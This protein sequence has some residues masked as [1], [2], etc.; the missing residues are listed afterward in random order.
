M[1]RLTLTLF[2]LACEQEAAT[3]QL[4]E[5]RGWDYVHEVNFPFRNFDDTFLARNS[6]AQPYIAER[7]TTVASVEPETGRQHDS[8]AI[9]KDV[10]AGVDVRLS[11]QGHEE[12]K[13]DG[14]SEECIFCFCSP[15]VPSV[16]QHWIEHGQDAHKRNCGIR[17]KL[18][19]KFWSMLNMRG[20]W[21]HPL[22]GRK[23]AIAM[24]QDHVDATVV[25]VLREIMME[26]VLKLMRVLY[27]NLPDTPYLG[28]KWW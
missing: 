19:R 15:C 22:Y 27:P 23:T 2:E 18:Y 16:R 25:H 5:A 24:C 8:S 26:C 11:L 14:G 9:V 17:K 7:D 3:R 13:W 21:R 1:D 10:R 28:H 20:A 6:F 4:F 12:S